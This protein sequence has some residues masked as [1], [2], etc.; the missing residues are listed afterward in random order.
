MKKL[1]QL[2]FIILSALLLVGVLFFIQGMFAAPITLSAIEN[3]D[4]IPFPTVATTTVISEKLAHSDIYL[5]QPVAFR[6]LKLHLA[7]DPQ[8]LEKLEVG[9]RENSF[10]L[11]YPKYTLYDRDSEP[12][13]PGTVMTK[14]ITIPLTDKLQDKDQSVD[15]MFFATSKNSQATEDEKEHDTAGFLLYAIQADSTWTQPSYTELKDY[16]RSIV[17]RER[18]L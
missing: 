9:A 18:A 4:G 3:I 6:N 12:A 11:S 2:I 16:I 1:L 5:G 10:W 15:L 7:F 14:D 13:S 8:N 17:Y